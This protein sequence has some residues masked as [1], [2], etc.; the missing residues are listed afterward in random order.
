MRQGSLLGFVQPLK[1]RKALSDVA[2]VVTPPKPTARAEEKDKDVD[3]KAQ[4]AKRPKEEE[5]VVV[6]E[7]DEAPVAKRRA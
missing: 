7:P 3:A 5:A 1:G 4:A 2:S 6:D